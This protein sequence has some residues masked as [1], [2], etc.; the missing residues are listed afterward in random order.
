MKT[1][2]I[3]SSEVKPCI[4]GKRS[5]KMVSITFK[6]EKMVFFVFFKQMMLEKLD[7]HMQ[8]NRLDSYIFYK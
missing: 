8:N 4:Y 2:A 6:G 3:E 1:N 7:S 5:F